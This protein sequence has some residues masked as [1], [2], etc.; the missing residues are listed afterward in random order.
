M[1][2]SCLRQGRGLWLFCCPGADKKFCPAFFKKLA[3]GKATFKQ[4]SA[5]VRSQENGKPLLRTALYLKN[6]DMQVKNFHV[7]F[8]CPANTPGKHFPV[9]PFSA[10]LWY[11]IPVTKTAW[12]GSTA[13]NP[14]GR[15][16]RWETPGRR[17]H[18]PKRT[19][20]PG[21]IAN[22]DSRIFTPCAGLRDTAQKNHGEGSV[23]NRPRFFSAP[24]PRRRE[25]RFGP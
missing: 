9:L 10:P 3:V 2:P 23:R 11:D 16:P 15:P 13:S 14:L 18:G 24:S 8:C 6:E 7:L 22:I 17:S 21:N 20:R 19:A 5:C 1:P 25:D 4:R 12:A